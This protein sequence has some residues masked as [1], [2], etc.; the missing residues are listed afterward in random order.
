R[1]PVVQ[2]QLIHACNE[3]GVPVITAT[4]MLESMIS[5]PT[6]T[7]AEATDVANAVFDGTDAVM[8]SAESASGQYPRESVR[9]MVR[10]IL[11]AERSRDMW[12][13]HRDIQPMPGSIVDAIESS[14]AQIATQVG[15]VAIACITHS[16]MAAR[17]LAK[18]RP[19][20]PIVAILDNE[21][22]LR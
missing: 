9:T 16:G 1:V 18:Y 14:A 15:A 6:P 4:Q 7:R 10:I 21:S 5:S 3:L 22:M 11:E 17:T 13:R 8:L 12:S 2:K 20:T 19:E